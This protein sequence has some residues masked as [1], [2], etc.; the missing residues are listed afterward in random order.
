[1]I[2]NF[3]DFERLALNEGYFAAGP[4]AIVKGALHKW[5]SGW[6][7]PNQI[8]AQ[9]DKFME[10]QKENFDSLLHLTWCYLLWNKITKND[11]ETNPLLAEFSEIMNSTLKSA[12]WR[13]ADISVEK[14]APKLI[15]DLF[16]HVNGIIDS[17]KKGD[18]KKAGDLLKIVMERYVDQPGLIGISTSIFTSEGIARLKSFKNTLGLVQSGQITAPQA[19]AQAKAV[20][21][22]TTSGSRRQ[23]SPSINQEELDANMA[24]LVD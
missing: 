24:K 6:K 9:F 20:M 5:M 14:N 19:Q 3:K 1:M 16:G 8:D 2:K 22:T 23:R 10:T 17:I 12:Y 7:T 15:S 4:I 13:N 18:Y 21:S 11:I